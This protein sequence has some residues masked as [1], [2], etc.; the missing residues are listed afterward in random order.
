MM[1]NEGMKDRSV[2]AVAQ[3]SNSGQA[4]PKPVQRPGNYRWKICAL[5]FFA[6]T[7]NYV[8]RAVLGILAPSLQK[9]IG[10]NEAQYGYIVMSFMAAYAIGTLL[11]G[12]LIDLIGTRLGYALSIIV[13]SLSAM[14]HSLVRSVSG[15]MCA[16]FALGLGES[17]G[18]PAGIKTVAEW[19]PQK[20]RALATG[21]FNSGTN[22][23]ATIAPLVVPWIALKLG[24][25]A[26]FLFTG[27][28][29]AAWLVLWLSTYRKP[30]EHPMLS[31]SELS[32]INAEPREPATKLP[33][34][35]LLGYRQTWAIVIGKA[36]SDPVWF[37]LLFWLPK[38]FNS[39]FGLTAQ[40][41]AL[42]LIIIYNV[43]AAGSIVGGWLP[44]KF[45]QRGYTVN[46]A[47]KLTML[48]CAVAWL[49]MILMG[50]VHNLWLAVALIGL[51]AA[52][53]QGWSANLFTLASDMFPRRAVASVSGMGLFGGSSASIFVSLTIGLVLQLTGSN[54]VPL[55]VAAGSA[56][57]LALAV[58][59]SFSPRLLP[60]D[61]K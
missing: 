7:I 12:R 1:A 40:Q 42:P 6:T 50:A 17:G 47:R 18:F 38:F 30:Q 51:A 24:W 10:W 2:I 13:W 32:Y 54:Y 23:G 37:F 26:A 25:Q 48:L 22:L 14:G 61:M 58:I 56:Y 27:L 43:A 45:L 11:V 31:P 52:A 28:F 4:T 3:A 49:P 35:R 55:F 16:R 46:S 57:L 53:H 15:F 19:F 33:W 9:S 60:A 39:R 44:A 36:M 41:F 20:E 29:S 59:H 5:L 34:A 8:D 21:I